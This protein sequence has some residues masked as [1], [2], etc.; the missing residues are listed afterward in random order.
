MASWRAGKENLRKVVLDPQSR[1][2]RSA[3][4]Q[5]VTV[6]PL[7]LGHQT[8]VVSQGETLEHQSS[9]VLGYG[10]DHHRQQRLGSSSSAVDGRPGFQVQKP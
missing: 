10:G 6:A 2:T 7:G 4:L 5:D 1:P 3:E 9:P 8:P